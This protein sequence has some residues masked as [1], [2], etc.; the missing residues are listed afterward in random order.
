MHTV[1]E[2]VLIVDDDA[3]ARR[4][5]QVRLHALGCEPIMAADGR[6]ALDLLRRHL[7]A[8]MLLDLEMF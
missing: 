1:G 3:S 8:A 6:E 7:P 5:L 4:L 2:T